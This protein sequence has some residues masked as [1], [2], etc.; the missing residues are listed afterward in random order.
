[1]KWSIGAIEVLSLIVFVG[2]AVDYCLHLSP[3]Q[4]NLSGRFYFLEQPTES[5]F[6]AE[7]GLMLLLRYFFG[8]TVLWWLGGSKADVS[9]KMK[10]SHSHQVA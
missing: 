4:K 1:M 8:F 7:N 9:G 3:G 10:N 5:C 2:F 6:G